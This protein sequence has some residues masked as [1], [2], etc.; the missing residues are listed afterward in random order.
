MSN[1]IFPNF[2]GQGL[3]IRRTAIWDTLIQTSSSGVE[4]RVSTWSY[5]V[6]EYQLT[7]E[8]LRSN[9]GFTELQTL[10][11]FFNSVRGSFDD[12]LYLDPTDSVATQQGFGFGNGTQTAFQLAR[13][14][15][16]YVEPVRAT[17]SVS[18]IR[19]AGAPTTAWTINAATGIVTFATPPAAGSNL[20]WT[21]VFYWRCRFRDSN[22]ETSLFADG[23]SEART[24][25]FRTLK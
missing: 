1:L 19:V 17:A 15:G 16:G 7:F 5:P 3:P 20:D 13:T 12:W 10:Y 25:R 6:W 18:Q 14:Y 4:T 23:F 22:F 9:A 21:G 24:L 2:L 8:F 11:G